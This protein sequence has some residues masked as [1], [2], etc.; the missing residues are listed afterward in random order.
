MPSKLGKPVK[1]TLDTNIF[2][3]AFR[4]PDASASLQRFLA[5]ALPHTFLSAVVIQE[6]LAGAMTA[7]ATAVLERGVIGPFMRR[8]RICAPTA[9]AY[10]ESGRVLAA[11]A[12]EHGSHFVRANRSLP[13]DT[14]LAASCREH[15]ITL[16]TNDQD[17]ALLAHHLGAWKSVPPWPGSA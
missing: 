5:R 13:N 17:F 10:R 1:Y 7:K 3:D 2:I 9:G 8:R 12:R 16:I 4:T 15:G 6:L 11:L 14:L